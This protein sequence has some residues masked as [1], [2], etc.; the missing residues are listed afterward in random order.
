[1]RGFGSDCD[2]GRQKRTACQSSPEVRL[3]AKQS[4][5]QTGRKGLLKLTLNLFVKW[6]MIEMVQHEEKVEGILEWYE[7][8]RLFVRELK[9]I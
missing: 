2:G 8:E 4:S 1:L 9:K 6:G 5:R 7:E 3:S